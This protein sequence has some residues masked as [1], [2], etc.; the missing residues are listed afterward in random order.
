FREQTIANLRA[1]LQQVNDH[2][3]KVEKACNTAEINLSL[4]N[5]QHKRELSQL[6]RELESWKERPNL[7]Q[8]ISELEERNNEMEE[9]L[10]KK[11]EEIEEN[12]D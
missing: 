8:A 10:R 2:L 7:E 5:A 6:H 1:E 9:L 4:Q 11:C 3:T 12:D